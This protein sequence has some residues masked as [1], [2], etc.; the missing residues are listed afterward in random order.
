MS[1]KVLIK[2]N[3]TIILLINLVAKVW[4]FSRWSVK[5]P[6]AWAGEVGTYSQHIYTYDERMTRLELINIV[7]DYLWFFLWGICMWVLMWWWF[8]LIVSEWESAEF[9]QANKMVI[10]SL[11][12]IVLSISS[13]YAVQIILN[14][15]L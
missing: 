8:R 10:Y 4:A 9:K 6:D 1:Q 15:F 14:L 13:Y 11:A 2:L 3:L 12:G 5:L 7:N